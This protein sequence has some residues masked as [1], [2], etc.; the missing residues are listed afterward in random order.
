MANAAVSAP[1]SSDP[2]PT[3]LDR[4]EVARRL[5]R[6]TELERL[7]DVRSEELTW[8]NE[9]LVAELYSRSEVE[10]EASHLA[11]YDRVTGLPN[12]A[13]FEARVANALAEASL[14]TA[15]AALLLVGLGRMT[16]LRDTLGYRAGDAAARVVADR[17]RLAVRG[18]DL[19]ARI[20]DD[21][22]AV[23][24]TR[25]RAADDAATVARKLHDALDAPVPL[26]AQ[27]VRL[28]PAIGVALAPADGRDADALLA[29]ADSAMRRAAD[30]RRGYFQ[31]FHDG[32]ADQLARHL[33]LEAELR[34]ALDAGQF[35]N[36]YQ[37]RFALKRGVC[38]GVEALLRWRHPQRGL[39]APGEFLD[40]AVDTGLIVPIGARVLQQACVDAAAWGGRGTIAVNVSPRE[41]LGT[42][43]ADSVRAALHA[44]GLAP[45]RLQ[46]EIAESSL[47]LSANTEHI[48]ASL[49]EVRA[50]GVQVALDD[51]GAGAASLATLHAFEVDAL[52]IDTQ[53]VHRV[54]QDKRAA[55]VVQAV[56][57]LARRLR[58][59]V[60]AEGVETAAQCTFL[61]KIG[62]A[63]AQGY[64]FA[65]PLPAAA[66]VDHLA[67]KRRARR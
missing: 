2:A 43:L 25:L 36:H 50:L 55:A 17:L 66:V 21:T 15:P 46:L 4:T 12:R 31:F 9:R 39:L 44:S 64:L 37:P 11:R 58:V 40:V 59:R 14:D 48:G 8:M 33:T 38:V 62:C 54:P 53:F 42:T 60:V 63:E 61:R 6:L 22:F 24:L 27:A 20:G 35:V 52:K 51:F 16:H 1:T 13:T 26:E 56:V 10:A 29:R 47:A 67:P 5:Q 23:L 19:V 30:E 34:A 18:S 45:R 49:R 32:I 41:F 65:H 3:E 57:E 28:A 7:I